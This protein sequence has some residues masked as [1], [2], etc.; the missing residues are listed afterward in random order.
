M[1]TPVSPAGAEPSWPTKPIRVIVP[2]PAGG[3]TDVV[4]RTVGERLTEELG[5]PLIVENRAGAGGTIGTAAVAKA[6][7]DGHTI[8]IHSSTYTVAAAAFTNLPYD[9][10]KDLS[11]VIPLGST[12]SVLVVSSKKGY[13]TVHD[14]VAAA[15]AGSRLSYAGGPGS[16]GHLAA[17]R[18]RL[19]AG[20]EALHIPYRGAPQALPDV[21]SGRVDF[22]FS[23]LLPALPLLEDGQLTALAVSTL[24]R[25][26]NLPNV[27]TLAEAGFLNAEYEFW[28]AIF[29]PAQT[30]PFVAERLYRTTQ[31]ILSMSDVQQKL[32]ALGNIPMNMS[33]SEFQQRIK[34]E[35]S[36][37]LLLVKE[38][39]MKLD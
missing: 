16:A 3:L 14:L 24:E 4:A 8:L 32:V 34:A 38:T 21:I 28:N 39:G 9:S 33:S 29:V 20:F 1:G 27:P 30:P 26:P 7:P 15:K 23:P 18:F 37:N 31:K 13:R 12:A 17:E 36:A 5:H 19:S 10:V 11:A 6:P 35:I 25:A 22:Y 2:A